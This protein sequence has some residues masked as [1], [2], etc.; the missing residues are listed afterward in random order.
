[1]E[2]KSGKMRVLPQL[3]GAEIEFRAFYSHR[4]LRGELPLGGLN[5]LGMLSYIAVSNVFGLSGFFAPQFSVPKRRSGSSGTF[6]VSVA[7][8]TDGSTPQRL[9]LQAHQETKKHKNG[10]LHSRV[11]R[12]QHS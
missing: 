4:A 1:M 7:L 5:V 3:E 11:I 10:N 9:R 12:C 6:A 8:V 2:C